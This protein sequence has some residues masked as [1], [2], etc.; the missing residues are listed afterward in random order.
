MRRII[1]T[2]LLAAMPVVGLAQAP[3]ASLSTCL[4]DQSSG[5]DRKDL[6]KWVFLAMGAHPEIKPLLASGIAETTDVSNKTTADLFM[7]L[8]TESCVGQVKAAAAQGGPQAIQVAFATFGQL[9]MQELM[10]NPDVNVAMNGPDRFMDKAK[11]AQVL[12]GK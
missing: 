4:A 8:L 3:T 11:L 6:A 12:G 2:G 1:V 7:R 9:A 5:K 10:T